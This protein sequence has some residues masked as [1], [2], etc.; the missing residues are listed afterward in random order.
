MLVSYRWECR[1]IEKPLSRSKHAVVAIPDYNIIVGIV[2]L[3]VHAPF[4]HILKHIRR[5]RTEI[6]ADILA[7]VIDAA[8]KCAGAFELIL[9]VAICRGM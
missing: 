4:R 3:I 1:D 7:L 5:K 2:E 9:A 6:D 8:Y